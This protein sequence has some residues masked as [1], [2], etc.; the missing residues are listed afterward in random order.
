M[1]QSIL[2]GGKFSATVEHMNFNIN[3]RGRICQSKQKERE[4]MVNESC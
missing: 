1:D 3:Y 4:V 2:D